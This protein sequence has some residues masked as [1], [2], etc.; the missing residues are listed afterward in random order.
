MDSHDKPRWSLEKVGPNEVLQIVRNDGRR[1]ARIIPHHGDIPLEPLSSFKHSEQDL[2]D[3][4]E[5][6]LRMN[7]H[8]HL[9]A[10]L[11]RIVEA[12]D[13]G[14]FSEQTVG[15]LEALRLLARIAKGG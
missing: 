15:T 6:I 8:D 9:V 7:S 14:N 13:T 10:S 4:K 12:I 11:R 2:K 1:I 5:I 3:A